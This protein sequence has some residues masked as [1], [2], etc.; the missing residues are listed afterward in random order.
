MI[1]FLGGYEAYRRS[2]LWRL[3]VRRQAL[4]RAQFHCEKCGNPGE[5]EVYHVTYER[6]GHELP[7]DLQVL[8]A[9]CLMEKLATPNPPPPVNGP[10]HISTILAR[11]LRRFL[12]ERRREA[13]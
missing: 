1:T 13:A 12:D 9:I 8:C 6:L 7:E 5:L 3:H 2:P 4:A 11:Y 10:E